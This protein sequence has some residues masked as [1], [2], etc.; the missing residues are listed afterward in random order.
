M[1]TPTQIQ[2]ALMAAASYIST[3]PDDVNKF[4][5]PE[6]WIENVAKRAN[7]PNSG[8][9]AT[10]FT[11]G[12]DLVISFAGTY[13]G[14]LAD[15]SSGVPI[16][17]VADL[18]LGVGYSS[19]QL[20]QAVE[21]YL[22]RKREN[23]SAT[24]TLTGHSL[25]GG[26]AALVAVFFGVPATT[27]DQ[28]PF[29]NSAQSNSIVSN[30]YNI[31]TPDVAANLK[32]DLISAGYS[33]AE[34]SPLSSFLTER[35][36]LAGVFG[37]IPNANLV[38][39]TRVDGEFLSDW[40][41]VS[42]YDTIGNAPQTIMHGQSPIL[43]GIDLHSQSLLIDFLQSEATATATTPAGKKQSLG[44]V[45]YKLNDLLGMLFDK[46]L[47][48]NATDTASE[49][50]LERLV[51]HEFGNAPNVVNGVT[52]GVVAADAMLTRFSADLWKLAQD[53]GMTMNEGVWSNYSNYNNVSKALT[54]FA[55]QFYYEDTASAVDPNKQLFT[56]LTTAG[57]GSNGIQFDM[58]DVSK[59]IATA[60]DA[61]A[62]VDLTKAKG[63]QYFLNYLDTTSSFT[64]QERALIKAMLPQLRDW[65]VQA[66]SGGMT[67]T[68][69]QSH[70]AFMLGGNGA[71]TLT[72]GT[73]AD[74]LVGN[75]GDDVLNG[76]Q[77]SDTLLGG[78]GVD[79]YVLN[80]GAGQGIDTVLDSD[81]KGYLR[82]DT[83]NPIVLMGGTQYG[84]NRVFRGKD[85]NGVNHLYIF[86]TG[87]R[88]TGGD[89]LVDGAMLIK[90]YNPNTG[91]HMGITL[92]TTP[93][94]DPDPTRTLVG[95]QAPIPSSGYSMYDWLNQPVYYSF[96]TLGNV[97]VDPGTPQLGRAD[98]LNGSSG[99]DLMLGLGG[100]DILYGAA[101]DDRIYADNQISVAS[102]IATGNL[103]NT[104]TGQ[105]GDWLAG[106]S[107]EDILIGGNGNDVLSGGGGADLLIA[108]AGDDDILMGGG[109]PRW[110]IRAANDA[111]HAIQPEWRIAA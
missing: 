103:P 91:N 33:D 58:H 2:Y 66:G 92:D 29:A 101:G 78:I 93:V 36:N 56:D 27:F 105:R 82:D 41:P 44:E 50:F 49:N 47:Y 13:P 6:G 37:G 54:A 67:A 96:D 48:A 34:L 97:V 90:N 45:T 65:Y 61:N 22:D 18:A 69:T 25:G 63:Y 9:E 21:Y 3:R 85:A 72:G 75:A 104:G 12:T 76:G 62:E 32:A 109:E 64:S 4:P 60:M 5:A 40:V 7:E 14:H 110:R 70:G 16:D 68:D 38:T 57:T 111:N 73:K 39:N 87:D 31:Y 10:Y 88:S 108:G 84:D 80:S 59:D 46:N 17:F 20:L 30:P 23:P 11:S 77:G 106:G 19:P 100:G 89:L 74:L 8:F 86:V 15:N 107:G 99:N 35:S 83:G 95:D 52:V 79:T 94:S 81:H 26:L 71:D 24:I 53:G 28:A 98:A 42:M 1:S 51:R 43:S 102:A 55:M